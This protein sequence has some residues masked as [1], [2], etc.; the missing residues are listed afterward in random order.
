M[1]AIC[2]PTK[3]RFLNGRMDSNGE[4]KKKNLIYHENE[5]NLNLLWLWL[6]STGQKCYFEKYLEAP[7]FSWP[8]PFMKT[9]QMSAFLSDMFQT[10]L[11][12]TRVNESIE[13]CIPQRG[14]LDET[15]PILWTHLSVT[16][17][18]DFCCSVAGREPSVHHPHPIITPS[19]SLS[20]CAMY[21]AC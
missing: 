2:H 7:L 20:L 14:H 19:L 8:F 5:T 18:M 11:A 13:T 15:Q 1:P 9:N 3:A 16:P 12:D 21:P 4:T 6:S 10:C 17:A